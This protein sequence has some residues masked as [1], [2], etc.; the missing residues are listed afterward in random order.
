MMYTAS[1][2]M[3]LCSSVCLAQDSSSSPPPQVG[4]G[5][6]GSVSNPVQPFC[7]I[8]LPKSSNDGRCYT[9]CNDNQKN[10]V[11]TCEV[12]DW[13]FVNWFKNLIGAT[14]TPSSHGNARVNDVTRFA[15]S[16][17]PLELQDRTL[18]IGHKWAKCEPRN[19]GCILKTVNG[20]R[21]HDDGEPWFSI[22]LHSLLRSAWACK[23]VNPGLL[24]L[25]AQTSERPCAFNGTHAVYTSSAER[26]TQ[27]MSDFIC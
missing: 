11:F 12:L 4:Q 6:I 16:C 19:V 5:Y 26:C 14:P 27:F 24:G 9:Q 10:G 7:H 25:A 8:S 20:D 22:G 15:D 2:L 23:G 1:Y 13:S 18:L 21:C 3:I 17:G